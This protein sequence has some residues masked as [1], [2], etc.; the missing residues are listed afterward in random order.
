[1]DIDSD[2]AA[3]AVYSIG[4]YYDQEALVDSALKYYN[5]LIENYPES[6]QGKAVTGRI[7][8]LNNI[9]AI[10]NNDSLNTNEQEP[11]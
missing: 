9:M 2:L 11:N 6:V 3:P 4:Y 10:S 5:E 8:L 7:K 1:M